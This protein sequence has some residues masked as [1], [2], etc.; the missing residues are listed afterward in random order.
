MIRELSEVELSEA[1]LSEAELSEVEHSGE[2]IRGDSGLS[3]MRMIYSERI[4][5]NRYAPG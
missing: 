5:R 1:K 2:R 4:Q 3:E